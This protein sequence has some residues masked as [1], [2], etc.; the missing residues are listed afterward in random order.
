MTDSKSTP[1]ECVDPAV[2]ERIWRL[3]ESNLD[4]SIRS[5]LEAHLEVCHACSLLSRVEV[6]ARQLLRTEHGTQRP[7]PQVRPAA[8]FSGR[9]V[10]AR[11]VA[12]LAFAACLVLSITSPPRSVSPAARSRGDDAAHFVRPVEGEVLA[13][14]EPTL[15]WTR[16]DDAS[17]YLVDLR[18]DTGATV[19][20]GE[21]EG[22]S[23]R[24]P[25][26]AGL[27]HGHQYRAI[28][29][30]QPMDLIAP[31]SISVLFRSDGM[32]QQIVH[33]VR[34]SH[35]LL[36]VVSVLALLGLVAST[37]PLRRMT[38]KHS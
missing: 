12:G 3:E 11:I 22:T 23:L 13:S 35:P 27:E 28:L 18:D 26:S 25:T 24:V 17:R 30:T 19:W 20:K 36:Q 14:S 38:Q 32:W 15:E 33:R 8:R 10:R 6:K 7:L 2:G 31:G 29:S 4:A 1:F 37:L 21:S 9:A 5:E 16:I 34:W